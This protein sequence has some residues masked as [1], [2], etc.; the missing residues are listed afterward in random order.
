MKKKVLIVN[1]VPLNNGD[2]A[3]VLYAY[4]YFVDKGFEVEIATNYF[5]KIKQIYPEYPWVKDCLL[6]TSPSPRDRSLSRMP[7]SA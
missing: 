2:A 6:Y 5:K 1:A 3:L 7:S 4:H